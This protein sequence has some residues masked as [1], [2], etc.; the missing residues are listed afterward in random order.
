MAR[1]ILINATDPDES[2]VAVVADGQ[3]EEIHFELPGR[4]KM[5]HNIYRGRVVNVEPSIDAA[6]IDI[7]TDKNGFLHESDIVAGFDRLFDAVIADEE[8]SLDADEGLADVVAE[9]A[10]VAAGAEGDVP[11]P[12]AAEKPRRRPRKRVAVADVLKKGQEIVVQVTKDSIGN[13]GPTVSTNL[14]VPGRYLVLMP[15]LQRWG[16]SRKIEDEKERSRLKDVMR[17][18]NPPPGTGFIVRTAGVDKTKAEIE[19]DL[20]YLLKIW[21]AIAKRVRAGHGTALVYQESDLVTRVIRD[22]LDPETEEIVADTPAVAQKCRDFLKIVS[23]RLEGRVKLHAGKKPIL[24][25]YKIE[26]QIESIFERKIPLASGGSIVFDQAEAMVAIDVNSGR[27]KQEGDLEDTA[28]RTNLEAIPEIARQLRLRDLGGVIAIDFIDMRSEDHR[29]EVERA[30]RAAI[31]KDRA[32]SKITKLSPLGIVEMTRQRVGP[33][34]ARTFLAQ[35]PH[36]DGSGFVRTV[37]FLASACLRRLR[38]A[39]ASAR[40]EGVEARVRPE[41][42]AYLH[43]EKRSTLTALEQ[44]T[45]KSVRIVASEEL[46]AGEAQVSQIRDDGRREPETDDFGDVEE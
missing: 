22:L 12:A 36:C 25:H 26:E 44:E 28:Y 11:P 21:G 30:L 23:P 4:A 32:R 43:N 31:R 42:A 34:I 19:R 33:G 16:I 2:R 9:R 13:K 7:G 15:A 39:L 27:S 6:F 20:R 45:G 40:G 46:K 18:L 38:I 5:L 41:V 17:E 10:A 29:R 1:R 3:L 24:H 14:A 35:C 8:A 37:P